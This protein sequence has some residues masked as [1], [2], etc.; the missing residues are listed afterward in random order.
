[1]TTYKAFDGRIEEAVVTLDDLRELIA[2]GR[3]DHATYRDIGKAHEGLKIYARDPKGFRGYTLI[4][5]F[6]GGSCASAEQKSVCA[7]AEK[8]VAKFGTSVGSY[9]NG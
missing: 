6:A 4:G 1:M 3:F 5:G 2:S 9:G 8:I 7:E